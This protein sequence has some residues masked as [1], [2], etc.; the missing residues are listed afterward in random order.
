MLL[1]SERN[2]YFY[3]SFFSI[4]LFTVIAVGLW[5][6]FTGLFPKVYPKAEQ[7]VTARAG[8]KESLTVNLVN[9]IAVKLLPLISLD[10]AKKVRTNRDLMIMGRTEKAE[11][12]EA[13]AWAT[14]AVY[15]L[16]ILILSPALMMLAALV[17]DLGISPL[18]VFQ[19]VLI[20]SIAML[21]VGRSAY[22]GEL[23]KEIKKR[24]EAIEWELPQFSGTVL[25]SLGRTRNVVDIL[26]SYKKICGPS[27]EL[28]IERT[29]NDMKTGNQEQA[30]RNLAARV[31]SGSF[32]QLANGLIGIL[33]GDDQRNYFQIITNDFTNAQQEAMKKEILQRPS[34]LT[35]NNVLLLVGMVAMLFVAIAGY[36]MDASTGLF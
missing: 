8:K 32:T 1:T 11:M 9:K 12:F 31:N 4:L 22:M 20:V 5:M 13:K 24:K 33:S 29:L 3:M 14:G 16:S 26:E 18:F 36:L 30:I 15:T 28:E 2:D 6:L 34:K 19:I 10:D 7:A 25:Q 17:P 23:E 27:L 21:F 35:V